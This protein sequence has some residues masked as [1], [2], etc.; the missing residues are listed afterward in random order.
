MNECNQN[1]I[2]Q[3]ACSVWRLVGGLEIKRLAEA[4]ATKPIKQKKTWVD[5]LCMNVWSYLHGHTPLSDVFICCLYTWLQQQNTAECQVC[6]NMETTTKHTVEC[7]VCDNMETTTKH[8][9]EC[10]SVTTWKQQQNTLLNAKSVTTWK[11]PQNTV[12]CKSVTTWKQSQNTL[13]NGKSV[14]TWKQ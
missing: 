6:D 1:T 3:S 14:T 11:Q 2:Y 9:V 8:T 7:Q 13:L 5:I 12:E 4:K 10:K